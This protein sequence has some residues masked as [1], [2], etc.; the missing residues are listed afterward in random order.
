M[1]AS[2]CVFVFLAV[3]LTALSAKAAP[4]MFSRPSAGSFVLKVRLMGWA[5]H[6]LRPKH[7][8]AQSQSTPSEQQPVAQAKIHQC[9]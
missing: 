6:S 7:T 3:G 2:L 4:A 1:R 9:P 8:A 5:P